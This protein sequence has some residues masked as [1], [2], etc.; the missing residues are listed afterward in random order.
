MYSR[1]DNLQTTN[2]EAPDYRLQNSLARLGSKLPPQSGS[3]G[4]QRG[5]ES[6][7][8]SLRSVVEDRRSQ[9]HGALASYH[10]DSLVSPA[11][12]PA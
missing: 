6:R 1:T 5:A 7:S 2:R 12:T 9:A 3:L 4:L 8:L 11:A 10:G